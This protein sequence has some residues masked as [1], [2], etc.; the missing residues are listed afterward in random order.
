MDSEKSVALA[1]AGEFIGE[2]RAFRELLSQRIHRD[3]KQLPELTASIKNLDE[4][5]N[6]F[7]L[8]EAKREGETSGM[9]RTIIVLAGGVSLIISLAGFV[10]DKI[11]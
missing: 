3:E 8:R 9:K 1:M 5:F 4:K 6:E 7:L 10:L 11:Y 2:V